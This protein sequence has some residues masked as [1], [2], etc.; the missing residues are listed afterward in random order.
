[1]NRRT[2]N[3]SVS[4]VLGV[5]CFPWC[6]W[7]WGVWPCAAAWSICPS[8]QSVWSGPDM[9]RLAADARNLIKC[10]PGMGIILKYPFTDSICL[11]GLGL[12]SLLQDFNLLR[13][14]DWE[15][16]VTWVVWGQSGLVPIALVSVGGSNYHIL[17]TASSTWWFTGWKGSASVHIVGS[18]KHR[19]K[20]WHC[21]A[22]E[23]GLK[24]ME[25]LYLSRPTNVKHLDSVFYSPNVDDPKAK[26]HSHNYSSSRLQVI[27]I[28]LFGHNMRRDS[29]DSLSLWS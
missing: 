27:D 9:F 13:H 24:T 7:C 6:C 1:M 4:G 16:W 17:M 25:T 10:W 21:V 26:A 15:W 2:I 3:I 20:R 28:D 22:H 12:P 8:Y 19:S 18:H 5:I 23:L 11:F 14:S 29:R